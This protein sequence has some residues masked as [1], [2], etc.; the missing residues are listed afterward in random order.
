MRLTDRL[1][2]MAVFAEVLDTGGFTAA[3]RRLGVSKAAVSKAVA[4]LEAHLGERLLNRTTRRMHPTEA[5]LAF[6]DYCQGV[7]QQADAAEQHLGQLR[8]VPRGMLR[9]TAPLSFGIARVAPLLPALLA[10]H[11]ELQVALQLDDGVRDLVNDRIDLALRAGPL[12]DSGLVARRVGRLQGSVVAAPA[13]LDLHGTPQ[14]LADLARH[15]CLR[16]D[17]RVTSW[18]FDSQVAVPVG[19]G[20]AVNSTLAQLQA[21]RNGAGLALLSDYLS[22][23]DVA[24][25]RLV[26]VLPEQRP[27]AVG[28]F[29]VHPY[30]RH[31]PVK[32]SVAIEFFAEHLR[33]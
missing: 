17:E 28:L 6:Y 25:G 29:A 10:R 21:A 22:E 24:A 7:V 8:A 26:R 27:P 32:V 31:V 20:I 14:T 3:G 1:A 30:S 33:D 12:P 9:I 4:R 19:R 16:Y 18:T 11:P 5:G 23:A 15:A 2:D 13:Y